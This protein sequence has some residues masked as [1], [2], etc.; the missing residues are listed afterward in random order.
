[1][2]NLSKLSA[3]LSV[4]AIIIAGTAAF[5]FK[6]NLEN[7]SFVLGTLTLLV[8]LLVGLQIYNKIELEDRFRMELDKQVQI[9]A[10]TALFVAL[11]QLGRSSFNK[12]DK[13]DAIQSLLNALCV[14]EEDM[15]TP[16]AQEAYDYCI[17]RLSQLTKDV[18][19]EVGD[20]DE[21]DSY[22]KAI[23]KTGEK[24]LVGFATRITVKNS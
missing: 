4:L 2:N 7:A 1:M 14:W 9:G 15:N 19:F 5:S 16:L 23:L 17:S 18:M 3:I 22:I 8:T 13:V 21:K 6:T 24:E 10:N 12:G 20:A 11:A